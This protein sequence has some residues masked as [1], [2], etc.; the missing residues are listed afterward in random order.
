[1]NLAFGI[2]MFLFA[3]IGLI[4]IIGVFWAQ[5]KKKPKKPWV[6]SIVTC[7]V[8]FLS[9]V[10]L[11]NSMLTPEQKSALAAQ[12]EQQRAEQ[13]AQTAQNIQKKVEQ[14]PASAQNEQP[15]VTEATSPESV[16]TSIASK[17]LGNTFKKIEI[18]DFIDDPNKKFILVYYSGNVGY[19]NAMTRKAMFIQTADL[20]KEMFA[21]GIPIQEVNA[22]IYAD[23]KG[24]GGSKEMLAMKCQLKGSTAANIDWSSIIQTKFD[25]N[26]D[27][28]WI[29]P[30][31]RG[32]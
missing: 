18:K 29:V 16:L 8:F 26:L 5:Y 9:S 4:S 17:K 6:I 15:V 10:A 22:F 12:R 21:S 28:V 24:N 31:L 25:Q 2:A 13:S 3:L 32:E 20:F 1:M 23:M 11:Y 7:A 14:T 30:G 27:Y 19:D